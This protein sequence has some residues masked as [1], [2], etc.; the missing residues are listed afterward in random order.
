[1][2]RKWPR[3]GPGKGGA[4]HGEAWRSFQRFIQAQC[5][6]PFPAA[7]TSAFLQPFSLLLLK[8]VDCWHKII[9]Q[10][11][12]GHMTPPATRDC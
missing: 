7:S 10:S 11:S 5:P 6:I 3:T 12:C 2:Q 9:F 4:G 8:C 1:M